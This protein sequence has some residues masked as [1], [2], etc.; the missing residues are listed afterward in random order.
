M[1]RLAVALVVILG[2][3]SVA[4][5][6]GPKA[7]NRGG[8]VASAETSLTATVPASLPTYA[9]PPPMDTPSA[10]QSPSPLP[11]PTKPS[12]IAK[13]P[14]VTQSPAVPAGGTGLIHSVATGLCVDSDTN[15]AM[16]LNG[17]PLGGH[18]FGST[19]NGATTQLW[20]EGTPLS[21]DSEHGNGWYR[22]L[23]QQTGFCLDSN[24]DGA[25]YTLP[26][27]NPNDYQLW[28]R[29]TPARPAGV[30]VP[31]NRLVAYR[32]KATNRCVSLAA[33][34][35]TL[36]TLPCPSGNSWPVAMVFQRQ[37]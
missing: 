17:V 21:E 2:L 8:T 10:L 7:L 30:S 19:C 28:Q 1:A 25:I 15:P 36:R 11:D 3:L 12:H 31:A 20:R 27:L 6:F 23:D 22:L 13:R 32:N 5:V 24:G 35:K 18:A 26:C 4:L 16:T 9:V 33:S 34:D 37:K 14:T 29:I